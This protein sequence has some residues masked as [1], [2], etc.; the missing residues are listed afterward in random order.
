[1]RGIVP[2]FRAEAVSVAAKFRYGVALF[3]HSPSRHICNPLTIAGAFP[4]S[5]AFDA[6]WQ[7]LIKVDGTFA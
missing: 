5:M 3:R 2:V 6:G 1:L 4:Q 7:H